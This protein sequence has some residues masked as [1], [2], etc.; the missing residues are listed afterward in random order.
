[1]SDLTP[2][3]FWKTQ[4]R[5]DHWLDRLIKEVEGPVGTAQFFRR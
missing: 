1:M 4:G 5:A 3:K 2:P